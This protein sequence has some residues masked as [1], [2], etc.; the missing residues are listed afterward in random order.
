[1]PQFCNP[2]KRCKST[3]WS[4][5]WEEPIPND[6]YLNL[7]QPNGALTVLQFDTSSFICQN[8]WAASNTENIFTSESVAVSCHWILFICHEWESF[9]IGDYAAT[10]YLWTFPANPAYVEKMMV[11]VV[12]QYNLWDHVMYD[13]HSWIRWLA[14]E[15]TII[16]LTT[17]A[18]ISVW[19]CSGS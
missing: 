1:M 10:I 3:F 15:G 16:L 14:R 17:Q 7:Y 5:L 18:P 9:E 19:T 4:T 12:V 13:K 6:I 11:P 2:S 8:A